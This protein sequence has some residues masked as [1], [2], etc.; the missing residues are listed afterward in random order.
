MR[1]RELPEVDRFPESLEAR[2]RSLT[3]PPVPDDLE[4]RILAAVPVFTPHVRNLSLRRGPLLAGASI[5][6]VAACFMVVFVL[7]SLQQPIGGVLDSRL[8]ETPAWNKSEQIQTGKF[9]DIVARL[10]DRR[11]LNELELPMFSWPIH[12]TSAMMCSKAILRD[13]LE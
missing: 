9:L 3:P 1:R 5:A 12:E 8:V 10:E 6:S 7:R 13:L 2:L 11:G 4:A